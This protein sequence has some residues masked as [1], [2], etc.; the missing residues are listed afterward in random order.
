MDTRQ[1][2]VTKSI[3]LVSAVL[4]RREFHTPTIKP[5]RAELDRVVRS[6]RDHETLQLSAKQLLGTGRQTV[7]HL[8]G[9][10]RRKHLLP[11]SRRARL[12]LKGYP[13]IEESL[14]VPHARADVKA[15]VA[16]ARRLTKALRPHA[17]VFLSAGF[18][19]SFLTDCD[20][21]ARELAAVH[22][23]P[24]TARNRRSVATRS[25]AD[26]IRE[27]REIIAAIDAHVNAELGD[28][29]VLVARWKMAK[30][31]PSRMG[32]PRKTKGGG[33]GATAVVS[34]EWESDGRT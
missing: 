1:L 14:R 7:A 13:G 5:L 4:Q 16:A 8:K 19:K 33:D 29:P 20:Q 6:L 2:R 18:G 24:D 21:A 30:R 9:N 11:L 23:N 31:V 3:A 10:L 28:D 15:H 22:A 27:A 25:I 32:R 26:K 12:L 34:L 17:R